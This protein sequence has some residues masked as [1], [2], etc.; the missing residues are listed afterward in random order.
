MTTLILEPYGYSPRAIEA[1]GTLGPVWLSEPPK[2]M[3]E[4]VALLVVRLANFIDEHFLSK[5]TNLTAIVSPT[6]GL[7]HIDRNTCKK[8]G[9]RI[10]SLANCRDAIEEVTS[11]SELTLGLMISLLRHIPQ[12]HHDVTVHGEWNRDCYRSRQLSRLTLGIVGLGRIGGHMARY[13]H[14]LGMH[15]IAFDPYKP[16]ERFS[17]LQVEQKDFLSLMEESDIVSIHASLHEGTE[18]LI[19]AQ[20]I[21]YM[22]E[23]ALII[24]TA[25]GSVLDESAVAEAV[26]SGRLGGVAVDVLASEHS[27]LSPFESPL[28]MAA[29]NGYNVIVTPH[30][31]GCTSDAM[32]ITEEILAEVVVRE[33]KGVL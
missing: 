11:T 17:D 4:K 19:D 26:C 20:A 23:G 30:I 31:G 18:K 27:G 21:S 28:I 14:A 2:G 9:V 8:R 33:Y 25:R 13:A 29:R 6:T 10:F 5:Y 15:V 1:Y 22:R 7:N 3:D 12:A 16:S 24:N 32:Q